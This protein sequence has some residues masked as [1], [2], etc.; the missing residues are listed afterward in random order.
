MH[1]NLRNYYTEFQRIIDQASRSETILRN[2]KM[3]WL[4]SEEFP[5]PHHVAMQFHPIFMREPASR[6]LVPYFRHLLL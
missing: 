4:G 5:R 2:Y 3:M 6:C 1:F